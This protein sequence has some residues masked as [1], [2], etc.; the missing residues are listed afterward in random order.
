MIDSR[1][2]VFE[3]ETK[4]SHVDKSLIKVLFLLPMSK[5]KLKQ[6]SYND[7]GY[8]EEKSDDK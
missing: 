3:I 8:S 1:N 2:T 6:Q 7:V 5:A 4:M